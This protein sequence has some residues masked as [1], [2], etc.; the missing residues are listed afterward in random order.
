MHRIGVDIVDVSEFRVDFLPRQDVLERTYT[1]AEDAYCRAAPDPAQSFAARWA[2]KEAL[3]KAFGTGWTKDLKPR[4]VEI[5]VDDSG[6]PHIRLHEASAALHA[7]LGSPDIALSLSH[8]PNIA[9][10]VVSVFAEQS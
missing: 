4:S 6:A 8:L 5:C 1:D 3:V 9:I 7:A 2:A 10:A